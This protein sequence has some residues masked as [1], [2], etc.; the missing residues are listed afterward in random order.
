MLIDGD[1]GAAWKIPSSSL[2]PFSLAALPVARQGG[3]PFVLCTQRKGWP[4]V[5]GGDDGHGKNGEAS[6]LEATKGL[7]RIHSSKKAEGLAYV[8]LYEVR[9]APA[10]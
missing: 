2:P 6:I 4:A 10:S 1:D 7:V 5:H 9:S 3:R 8:V